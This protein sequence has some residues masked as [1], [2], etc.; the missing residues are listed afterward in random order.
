ML[1]HPRSFVLTIPR[2]FSPYPLIE[3]EDTE[4]PVG[5]ANPPNGHP[6]ADNGGA[7]AAASPAPKISGVRHTTARSHARVLDLLAGGMGR[8]ERS[9][10]WV[11]EFCFKYMDDSTLY[12]THRLKCTYTHPPGRKVYQRGAHSIWEVDGAV[13]K[14]RHLFCI[15]AFS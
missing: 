11:C 15:H 1:F 2:Y 9:M 3:N 14:V 12:E 8:G 10:L 7:S 5:G 6:N 4:L 13:Q